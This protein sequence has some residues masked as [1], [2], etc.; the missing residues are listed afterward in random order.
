M[1]QFRSLSGALSVAA[2]AF[3]V[4]ALAGSGASA[5]G[6]KAKPRGPGSITG[7]VTG[8]DGKP[9]A[10]VTVGLYKAPPKAEGA[11]ATVHAAPGKPPAPAPDK[12]IKPAPFKQ[13]TTDARGQFSFAAV[14]PGEYHVTANAKGVRDDRKRVKIKAGEAQRVELKLEAKEPAAK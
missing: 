3:L 11:A 8:A 2:A 5:A 9:A 13:T 7:T 4:L 12:A 1:S 6:D 14:P 10:G